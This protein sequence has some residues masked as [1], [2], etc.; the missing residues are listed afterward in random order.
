MHCVRIV[1]VEGER[2][3][4]CAEPFSFYLEVENTADI[5]VVVMIATVHI[6]IRHK[7]SIVKIVIIIGR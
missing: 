1:P 2:L 5:V 3:G 6:T 7:H 4:V